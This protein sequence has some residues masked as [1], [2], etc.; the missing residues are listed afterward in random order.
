[1]VIGPTLR[2]IIFMIDADEYPIL[3]FDPE[4]RAIIN[5]SDVYESIDISEHCVICFF[6]D[7]VEHVAKTHQTRVVFTERGVYGS[8]NIYE[9]EHNGKRVA[10]FHPLVGA[11]FAAAFLEIAI[12]LGCKKFVACGGAGVLDRGISVGDITIPT[13]AI[14]DEGVSYH[15]LP[16]GRQIEANVQA[17][18]AITSMLDEHKETYRVGKT[19]TTDAIFRETD[20][21]VKLRKSEGCIVVEM[22]AAALFAVAQFRDVQLGY[23]LFGGD[24]V[25][26]EEWDRRPEE[27]RMPI[28]EKLFWLS[29]EACQRL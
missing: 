28:A 15:Y 18:R 25:S 9:F 20:S 19:W 2:H 21:K 17:V 7:V 26:G 4:K 14:R 10:F 29:V 27:P 8:S 16:P 24:D 5:P 12:A 1:M 11:S 22:E 23:I 3:E 6:R 13:A